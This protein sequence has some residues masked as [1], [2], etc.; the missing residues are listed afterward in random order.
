VKTFSAPC[1]PICKPSVNFNRFGGAAPASGACRAGS[2][3]PR[4][5]DCTGEAAVEDRRRL[6]RQASS[7][8][9][10]RC[11]CDFGHKKVYNYFTW[12]ILV[13]TGLHPFTPLLVCRRP[14]L[15]R[16]AGASVQGSAHTLVLLVL[17]VWPIAANSSFLI[18][19]RFGATSLYPAGLLAFYLGSGL[20]FT[21]SACVMCLIVQ[22]D[23]L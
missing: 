17:R 7:D 21:L 4:T 23:D 6:R 12:F 3:S 16:E 1:T 18:I 20:F 22:A 13:Y 10:W 11:S 9:A 14:P 5:A 8:A 2:A 15:L 19:V